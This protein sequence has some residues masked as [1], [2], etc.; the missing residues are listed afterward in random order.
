ML[1]PQTHCNMLQHAAARCDTHY[2]TLHILHHAE[3][4]CN[5][6]QQVHMRTPMG[7]TTRYPYR[8][9]ATLPYPC[10]HNATRY[11]QLEYTLTHNTAL[12]HTA[13]H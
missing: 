4:R 1:P 11:S 2:S 8:H 13:I 7:G 10:G 3:T 5:S 6:L 9:N 12:E